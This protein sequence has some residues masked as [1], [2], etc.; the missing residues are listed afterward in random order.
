MHDDNPSAKLLAPSILKLLCDK[1]K[2]NNFWQFFKN[3]DKCL[4]PSL[5]ILFWLISKNVKF[6]ELIFKASYYKDS[7]LQ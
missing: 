5:G 1:F 7:K 3:K 2:V 4:A 6:Y